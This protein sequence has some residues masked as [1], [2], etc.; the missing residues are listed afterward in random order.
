MLCLRLT[1]YKS[2]ICTY[3][4]L[5]TSDKLANWRNEVPYYKTWNNPIVRDKTGMCKVHR[6]Q[7]YFHNAI[8]YDVVNQ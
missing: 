1:K 5:R 7:T 3:A 2:F 8:L 6:K 4:L